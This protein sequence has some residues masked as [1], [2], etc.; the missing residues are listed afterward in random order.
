VRAPV[1]LLAGLCAALP[2]AAV[3]RPLWELGLGAGVLQLPHYRGSDQSHAWL[4]PVPYV[5][6]RGR[7]LKADREGARAVLYESDRL[8]FDLSA[9]AST[10][11]RSRDNDAR[12]GMPDLPPT[13]E[14]G[15]NVNLTVARGAQWKL[16][17]RAPLRAAIT[18]E[19]NPRTVGCSAT[20]GVNLDLLNLRGWN[21]GLRAGPVWGD[22]RFNAHYYEVTPAQATPE[23]PAYRAGAGYGGAQFIAAASRR[24][25]HYWAGA[26]VK[27][28]TLRGA[29]FVDS[30]L[31]RQREQWSF[32]IGLSWVFATSS[33]LVD[34]PQ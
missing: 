14:L 19:S 34:V 17:L 6:Y 9:S 10:P 12:R 22:R 32:G 1:A 3:D 2:A 15:P 8:D 13:F 23:R 21:I 28:D 29:T 20:P 16:D 24:F 11:V 30:P 7:I 4:L 27:Y 25:D 31:V 5:V 33:R 26:F 18:L